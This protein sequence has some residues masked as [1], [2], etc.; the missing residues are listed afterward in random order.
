MSFTVMISILL[1]FLLDY[2]LGEAKRFHPLVG[3]GNWAIWLEKKFNVKAIHP[4]VNK[5]LGVLAWLL[6]VLPITI[7]FLVIQKWLAHVVGEGHWLNIVFSAFVLYLAIG[8]KSLLQHAMNIATPLIIGDLTKARLS[9]SMI[10]S[11]DT[12]SLDEKGIATAATESVLEN[13]GDA[14]FSALFWFLILGVPGVVMYRLSNTLD[15][16]WGYKNA[17]FLH[18]GW[19]AARIDDVLNFIPARLTAL[20]YALVGNTRLAIKCWRR[21]GLNWKSPNAGPVMAAGAGALNVSLGGA[22]QY[23]SQMQHRPDLGPSDV[24]AKHATGKSIVNACRL[25]N[26]AILIWIGALAIFF[27]LWEMGSL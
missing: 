17:R 20:S 13:G 19:C 26:R 23:H 15:A 11:R 6:A 16:M 18:F 10:V 9:V 7:L 21:Q 8:W 27:V 4:P 2:L 3:F 12:N 14:I 25:V 5:L 1:A 22:A 24:L